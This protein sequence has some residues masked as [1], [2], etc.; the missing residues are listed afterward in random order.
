MRQL[1]FHLSGK[2]ASGKYAAHGIDKFVRDRLNE[3]TPVLL[4]KGEA[5]PFAD[6][7]FVAD[8]NGDDDLAPGLYGNVLRCHNMTPLR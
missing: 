3:K 5:R 1:A 4:Y 7:I 6:P 2:A 8:A